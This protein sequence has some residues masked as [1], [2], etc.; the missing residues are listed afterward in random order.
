LRIRILCIGRMKDGPERTLVDDYV[1]RAQKTGKSLG[2]RAVEEIELNSSSKDDEGQRLVAKHD[3]G[4]LIRLDERGEAWTSQDLSRRLARWRDAGEDAVSFVIGG[5]DGT[6]PLVAAGP[7]ISF[8]VQIWPTLVRAM[9]VSKST[10]PFRSKLDHLTTAVMPIGKSTSTVIPAAAAKLRRERQGCVTVLA[11]SGSRALRRGLL[12]RMTRVG[13]PSDAGPSATGF[14]SQSPWACSQQQPPSPNPRRAQTL[15]H[16]SPRDAAPPGSTRWKKNPPPRRRLEIDVDLIAAGAD[17]TAREEAAYAAEEQLM[18]LA[19]QTREASRALT[20]DQAALEDLLAVLMTFGSRR[21]PT[22]IA[23]PEDAGS[24]IRSAILMTDAAPPSSNAA[25]NC[26]CAS[27]TS[28]RSPKRRAPNRPTTN[29]PPARSAPAARRSP[30]S[31][32]KSASPPLPS[33]PKRTLPAGPPTPSPP[34][35]PR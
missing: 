21:P 14:R 29:S 9:I 6:S 32:R 27:S 3:K 18:I 28:T 17:A 20:A 25:M 11:L 4:I 19:D 1:A 15:H 8:G 30:P 13:M 31:P 12:A 7:A 22:L 10:G 35:R 16:R 24:A 34:K 26:A 23:S 2:Y 5:A 33:T